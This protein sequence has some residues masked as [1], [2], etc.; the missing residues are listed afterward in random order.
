MKKQ[1]IKTKLINGQAL[2]SG[3]KG[4]ISSSSIT[5]KNWGTEVLDNALDYHS[6]ES[7]IEVLSRYKDSGYIEKISFIIIT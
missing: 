4:N 3:Y 5:E 2:A 6:T 1:L 7:E